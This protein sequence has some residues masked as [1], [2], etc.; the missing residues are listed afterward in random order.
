MDAQASSEVET[1]RSS[2]DASPAQQHTQMVQFQPI[3]LSEQEAVFSRNR[4]AND[5]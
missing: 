2:E 4:K 3:E 5:I 1:K